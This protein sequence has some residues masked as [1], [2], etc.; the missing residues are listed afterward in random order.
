[1]IA[2]IYPSDEAHNKSKQI[3]FRILNQVNTSNYKYL[4]YFLITHTHMKHTNCLTDKNHRPPLK[5]LLKAPPGTMSAPPQSFFPTLLQFFLI[6]LGGM[7]PQPNLPSTMN[8]QHHTQNLNSA[9]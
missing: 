6:D 1:M 4:L 5:Y 3:N 8:N 9:R 7:M 2:N